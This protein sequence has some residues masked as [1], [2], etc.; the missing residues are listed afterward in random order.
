MTR[1]YTDGRGTTHYPLARAALAGQDAPQIGWGSDLDP[2]DH[3]DTL[4]AACPCGW[5]G[6]TLTPV[7]VPDDFDLQTAAHAEWERAHLRLLLQSL[8]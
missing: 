7:P 6:A 3:A 5:R 4:R 2:R 1:E 8:A